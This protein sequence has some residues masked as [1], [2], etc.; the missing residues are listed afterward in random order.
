M[1]R[2]L[3]TAP[4]ESEH[5]VVTARQR[6]REIAAG[7]GFD[8]QDQTRIATAVSEIARNAVSYGGKGYAEFAVEDGP[9][10]G[11]LT[12]HV[13]DTGAGIPDLQ[14]VM[15]GGYRSR[16]GMGLGIS[17]A[18]R[19]MDQFDI[20]SGPAG[21]RVWLSKRLPTRAP[22]TPERLERLGREL[23]REAPHGAF[24]ELRH[25]NRELLRAM[26]EV[27]RRQE[28]MARLSTELEE[29]NRGVVALTKELE[30]SAAALR[31]ASETKSRFLSYMSHEF[32]TPLTSILALSR[33]LL[34]Q[35]DGP[36]GAEQQKQVAFIRKSAESLLEIVSDLLD[37]S[38]V[39][40][41]R[42]EV[43]MAPVYVAALFGT[44]RGM[45][46]PLQV[47]DAVSLVFEE[48]P[49]D[50]PVLV[51]DESKLAQILRNFVSN[52]LKFT[53]RG[54]VRVSAHVA[55]GAVAIAVRDTGV[56]IPVEHQ[57]RIFQEFT[58]IENPMQ[59]ATRGTGLGLSLSK[60]LAELLGGRVGFESRPGEG[61]AFWVELPVAKKDSEAPVRLLIIDDE[62]VSR[63][64]IRES[65][66]L[67]AD[68]VLEAASGAEGLARARRESPA[69]IFL[70]VRMPGMNGTEVLQALK[71]DAATRDIPV[72]VV[73]SLTVTPELRAQLASAAAVISKDV[74]GRP[75]AAALM[76]RTLADAGVPVQK[77]TARG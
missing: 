70:D 36:L 63:Y 28:E 50:L 16:T 21:T 38:K 23:A 49:R 29:T 44:L 6:A 11:R 26:D 37:I 8:N 30:D 39:E 47:N 4:L 77:L 60:K 48:T 74:L 7:L 46:K 51:T 22:A 41:G 18:R 13:S 15:E 52:A 45:M 20:E 2:N 33:L 69:A 31:Q 42:T 59:R 10:G 71:G 62:E 34:N 67:P 53:A 56:G 25:E 32:R 1:T 5:D 3:H 14:E 35:A 61:S 40:A 27:R 17:G 75:D 64:L 68:M 54:E 65:L 24:E 73:T 9:E 76:G 55:G 43:R 19:L 12:V 72:I 58:Q 66:Q 57:S